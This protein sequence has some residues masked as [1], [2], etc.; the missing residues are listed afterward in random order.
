MDPLVA[1]GTSL[2]PRQAGAPDSREL[3]SA[4]YAPLTSSAD[5]KPAQAAFDS[6]QGKDPA[7]QQQKALH[8]IS[9]VN[10]ECFISLLQ[11][12]DPKPDGSRARAEYNRY[13]RHMRQT[14]ETPPPSPQPYPPDRP[15]DILR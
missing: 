15:I 1:I 11:I 5:E 9:H 2:P 4:A 3:E 7:A 12:S 6:L 10:A 14:L 13:Y 8:L